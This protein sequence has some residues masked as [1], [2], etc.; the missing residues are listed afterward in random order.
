MVSDSANLLAPTSFFAQ[1]LNIYCF[2]STNPLTWYGD[3]STS[4]RA[5]QVCRLAS[6]F[7]RTYAVTGLPPSSS[8]GCQ[9]KVAVSAVMFVT[10]TSLGTDGLSKAEKCGS[11][12]CTSIVQAH[13]MN[14]PHYLTYNKCIALQTQIANKCLTK[15]SIRFTTEK[16]HNFL[17][18]RK[19]GSRRVK[20]SLSSLIMH[21]YQSLNTEQKWLT[22]KTDFFSVVLTKC[23]KCGTTLCYCWHLQEKWVIQH[24]LLSTERVH[25]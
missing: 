2:P 13:L 15:S 5:F 19:F 21:D 7:S 14:T 22:V 4:A 1:T 3:V 17:N 11:H 24:E 16:S 9:D 6:R 25:V 20:Q 18:P 10:E 8:G 23:S 12:Q